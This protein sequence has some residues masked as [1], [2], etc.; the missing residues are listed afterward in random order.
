MTVSKLMA[1]APVLLLSLTIIVLVL[2][3]SLKRDHKSAWYISALGL[4]ITLWGTY[5][6]S[7]YAQQVTV[8]IKVDQWGLLFTGLIVVST[9]TTLAISRDV[10]LSECIHRDG[11]LPSRIG[12]CQ[13]AASLPRS[14]HLLGTSVHGNGGASYTQRSLMWIN[15]TTKSV[16]T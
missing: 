8:L 9:L 13:H 5:Y 2:H 10:F 12:V 3:A 7:E 1:L 15:S 4:M 14:M 16:K 11:C 6:A